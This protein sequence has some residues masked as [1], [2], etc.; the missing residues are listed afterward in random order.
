MIFD[1]AFV[2]KEMAQKWSSDEIEGM[3]A[4]CPRYFE[5]MNDPHNKVIYF[6]THQLLSILFWRN[7]VGFLRLK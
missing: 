2:V 7:C 1:D 3:F 4:L 5:Y 6:D